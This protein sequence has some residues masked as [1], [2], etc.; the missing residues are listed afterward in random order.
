MFKCC[1][2]TWE[3]GMTMLAKLDGLEGPVMG[4]YQVGKEVE[5]TIGRR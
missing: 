2:T 1:K 4:F 5:C 3:E